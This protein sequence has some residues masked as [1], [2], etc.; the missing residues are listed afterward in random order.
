MRNYSIDILETY[1]YEIETLA[2]NKEEAIKK[3]KE[4]Y[5]NCS[6]GVIGVADAN[7]HIKTEF[8]IKFESIKIDK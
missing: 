7:S 6:D 5:E 8:K 4:L 1:R 2:N 3:A